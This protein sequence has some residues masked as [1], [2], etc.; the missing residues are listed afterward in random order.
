[1]TGREDIEALNPATGEVLEHLDQQPPEALTEALA[2]IHARQ[3]ELK[4]W[5]DRIEL[6]L[7]HRLKI[8]GN[9]K[10]AIFGDWEVEAKVDQ[11]RVWDADELEGVLTQLREDGVIEAA[12]AAG[13][14]ERKATVAGRAALSLRGRLGPDAQALIDTT[15]KWTEKRRPL[16]VER[17]VNLLDAAP[18]AEELP[19]ADG[20]ATRDETSAHV[21]GERASF[22]SRQEDRPTHAPASHHDGAATAPAQ[23]SPLNPEELFA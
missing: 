7:R 16:R 5:G 9:R 10:F 15:W 2:E 3:A 6:E 8:L 12:E 1:M 17:S 13:V 23:P 21:A 19:P 11:T 20:Q 14:I 18:A 22:T 4:R